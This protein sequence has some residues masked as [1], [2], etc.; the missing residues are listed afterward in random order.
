[1]YIIIFI[2]IKLYIGLRISVM[3]RWLWFIQCIF[4]NRWG[5]SWKG[6]QRFRDIAFSTI[7]NF[8]HLMISWTL[9]KDQWILYKLL[10]YFAS[11]FCHD[12]N[13]IHTVI[14]IMSTWPFCV[15]MCYKTS[16]REKRKLDTWKVTVSIPSSYHG[17]YYTK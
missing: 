10:G 16:C 12:I 6:W 4:Q 1:M 13:E 8:N 9:I 11:I 14:C 2:I 15:T 5:E 7:C 3:I 17:L